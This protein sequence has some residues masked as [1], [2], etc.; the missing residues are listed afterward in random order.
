M[1]SCFTFHRIQARDITNSLPGFIDEI[2]QI[3]YRVYVFFRHF[4]IDMLFI[5]FYKFIDVIEQ[6]DSDWF[7]KGE[8]VLNCVVH[9]IQSFDNKTVV[10]QHELLTKKAEG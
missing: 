9:W 8:A 10:S 1:P 3:Q 4:I 5:G 6:G 7:G 2:P